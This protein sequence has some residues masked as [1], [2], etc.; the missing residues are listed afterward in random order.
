V[1]LGLFA[2]FFADPGLLDDHVLFRMK[3]LA[4]VRYFRDLPRDQRERETRSYR[5]DPR[6]TRLLADHLAGDRYFKVHRPGHS[7]DR[8]R[9]QFKMVQSFE[10]NEA[11][12]RK[13]VETASKTA[14]AWPESGL[15]R[16]RPRAA[17]TRVTS[18]CRS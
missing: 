13:V 8:A 15:P 14:T 7:A 17:S 9:V 12:M 18:R 11:A 6:F 3:D 16:P 5:A 2:A 1:L 10:R 4:G